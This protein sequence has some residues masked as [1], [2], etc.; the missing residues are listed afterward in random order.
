MKK[1][2]LSQY[3]NSWYTPAN[4]LKSI[5]WYIGNIL[6]FKNAI[7]LPQFLKK[8]ILKS[9]G[10]KIGKNVTIKPY[11][12]IKYPWLL[13]I[14]DNVWIGEHVWIDNLAEVTIASN[15]CIS[16]GAM[17]LCGNH[18]YK[19]STFN[20]IVKP[21]DLEEGVWIGAKSIVCPGVTCKSHAIL[22]VGSV[23]SK[24]LEAYTIYQGNPAI[25]IRERIVK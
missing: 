16:Q 2:D 9:F 18:D 5:I 20:L 10:C 13:T 12:S 11:V 25:K 8:W 17:L 7:P 1:V 6:F 14:K 4:E 19:K 23:A 15:V 21:I 22:S 3:D 24:D